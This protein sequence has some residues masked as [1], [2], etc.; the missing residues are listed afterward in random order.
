M[1]T[2]QRPR[3]NSHKVLDDANNLRMQ[4]ATKILSLRFRMKDLMT[5]EEWKALS[6]QMLAYSNR[7]KHSGA[8]QRSRILKGY[9]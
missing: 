1:R 6:D 7:Y 4:S 2:T 8:G 3:R 5:V 9:G